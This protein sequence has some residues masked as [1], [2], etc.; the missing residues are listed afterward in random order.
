MFVFAN[1]VSAACKMIGS[2]CEL[3]ESLCL[4]VEETQSYFVSTSRGDRAG[5]VSRH[6]CLPQVM[7]TASLQKT[8]QKVSEL[9]RAVC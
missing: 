6:V 1:T 3:L 9:M 4:E 5:F 2:S 7:A 8:I